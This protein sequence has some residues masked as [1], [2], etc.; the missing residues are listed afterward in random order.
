MSGKLSFAELKSF[1]DEK[2]ELYN[3]PAF[4]EADPVSIPHRFSKKEDIEISAFLAAT[5][6]WGN[7]KSIITSA[8]RMMQLMDESPFD[9]VM[10][11]TAKDL[12]AL[13]PFVHRTFNSEDFAHFIK[14][15]KYIYTHKGGL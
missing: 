13:K 9:Y 8:S 15:L 1:L 10:H 7:R 11:H 14:A 4:V 2:A 5:I 12:K 3:S 6:A